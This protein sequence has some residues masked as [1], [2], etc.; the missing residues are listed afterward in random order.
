MGY[1]PYPPP[2][3]PEQELDMLK[4]QAE[5]LEQ[6]LSDIRKRIEELEA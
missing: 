2:P 1:G 4:D 5:Y 3:A 6:A